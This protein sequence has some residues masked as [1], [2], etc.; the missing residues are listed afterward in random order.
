MLARAEVA[1][2]RAGFGDACLAATAA[3]LGFSVV[4]FNTKHFVAF[5]VPHRRPVPERDQP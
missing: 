3:E 5:G 4:T 1:G 2:Q